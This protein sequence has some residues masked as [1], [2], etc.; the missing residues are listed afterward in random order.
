MTGHPQLIYS[1]GKAAERTNALF[2]HFLPSELLPVQ[3]TDPV[4]LGTGTRKAKEYDV[5]CMGQTLNREG[6][7]GIKP[8][9]ERAEREYAT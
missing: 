9:R 8:H 1:K 5:T 3:L 2:I 6:W 7:D 4:G